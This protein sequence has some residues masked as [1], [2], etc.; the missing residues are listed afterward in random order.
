[1]DSNMLIGGCILIVTTII[2]G[3]TAYYLSD[4][5]FITPA[6]INFSYEFLQF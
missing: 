2:V 5:S 6:N 3:E 4:P 1:M